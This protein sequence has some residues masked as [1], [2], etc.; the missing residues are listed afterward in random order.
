MSASRSKPS[1][2]RAERGRQMLEG[3]APQALRYRVTST[4]D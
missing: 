4:E 3:L 2:A 1:E